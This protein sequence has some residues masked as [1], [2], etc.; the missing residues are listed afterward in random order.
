MNKSEKQ[1][2]YE[3]WQVFQDIPMA[4]YG[5]GGRTASLAGF[6]DFH[7]DM[8]RVIPLVKDILYSLFDP[9][10]YSIEEAKESRE[11]LKRYIEKRKGEGW[12]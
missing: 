6:V 3:L 9:D 4:Q 10:D 5:G 1:I 8:R 12:Q 2:M 11:E 7:Q